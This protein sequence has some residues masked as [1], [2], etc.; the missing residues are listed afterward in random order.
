MFKLLKSMILR[1]VIIFI[2][3]LTLF[4]VNQLHKR[5]IKSEIKFVDLEDKTQIAF[6]DGQKIITTYNLGK[7]LGQEKEILEYKTIGE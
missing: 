7:D 4:N 3:I 2:V 1:F 5:V 6:A